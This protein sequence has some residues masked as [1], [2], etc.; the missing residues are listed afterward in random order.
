MKVTIV[1]DA[2]MVMELMYGLISLDTLVSGQRIKFMDRAL[3]SGLMV[4]DMKDNGTKTTC[5][6]TEFTPGKMEDD[7]KVAILRTES[8]D[9][10]FMCGQTAASM[11][12]IGKTVVSTVLDTTQ[13][14]EGPNLVKDNGK[15]AKE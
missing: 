2:S 8:M 14:K 6:D 7:T 12:V 15:R 9:M 11:K 1:K 10:E 4:V 5:T 3:T 13:L